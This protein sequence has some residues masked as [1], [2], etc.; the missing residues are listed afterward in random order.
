MREAFSSNPA[1]DLD[2]RMRDALQSYD[3]TQSDHLLA[4][5]AQTDAL[6]MDPAVH[7]ALVQ[8]ALAANASFWERDTAELNRLLQLR[9]DGFVAQEALRCCVR[10]RGPAGG[11][12]PLDRLL[13]QHH[14]HRRP[15]PGSIGAH[16]RRLVDHVVTL[17]TRDE[18]GQVVTSFNNV[19]GRLRQEWSLAQ[20]ESRRARAAELQLRAREQELMRAKE[21]A[22]DANRAKSQFL[23]NMSHELRTPL[24]AIIGYSEMLQEASE[25]VG[26]EDFI[27][28][29]KKIHGAGKHLLALINDILDL[30]KIEAGKMT[31]FLET[32]D[33]ANSCRRSR[34][35]SSR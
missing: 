34:R 4:L 3:A 22:E 28:D 25:D 32:F 21:A 7:D 14:A 1:R 27:P 13:L 24:N 33:V 16:G 31:L 20:E 11:A 12:L 29:L 5:M 18:L 15:A 17:D 23:A 10:R 26:Q 8:K 19:A 9:I 30:S 35:R 6:T 2:L